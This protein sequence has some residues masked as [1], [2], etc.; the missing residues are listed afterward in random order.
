MQ[1]TKARALL[2]PNHDRNIC[3]RRKTRSYTNSNDISYIPRYIFCNLVTTNVSTTLWIGQ[4]MVIGCI[5]L[6][7]GVGPIE[8]TL[9]HDN[10][11][12]E[13]ECEHSTG[14]GAPCPPQV[15]ASRTRHCTHH[16]WKSRRLWCIQP[17]LCR[18]GA[19]SIGDRVQMAFL[20]I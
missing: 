11:V 15:I 7:C 17:V 10:V 14:C 12:H 20:P 3:I 2:D 18:Q 6:A 9:R 19:T 5:L 16:E 4:I 1:V 13:C 8:P